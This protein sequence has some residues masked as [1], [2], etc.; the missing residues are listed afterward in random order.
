MK[1]IVDL[2]ADPQFKDM[3]VALVNIATDSLSELT[4][5]AREYNV[6]TPLL[7][8]A[9]KQMSQAY[10]ILQWAMPSGEPGHTF[11]LVDRNGKIAW[12]QDYGA[13][14]NGGAMYVP[15]NDLT[16]EIKQRLQAQ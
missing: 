13:P 4:P 10:G 3:N 8:D 1:Q 2:Q 15:V 9:D 14:Q 6:T 11:V 12:I 16:G 7:S 5:V